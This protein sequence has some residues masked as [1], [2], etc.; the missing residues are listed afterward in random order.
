MLQ[1]PAEI[2]CH[3]CFFKD[4]FRTCGKIS[5]F[6]KIP[7]YWGVRTF[8][9]GRGYSLSDHLWHLFNIIVYIDSYTGL[10]YTEAPSYMYMPANVLHLVRAFLI[11]E[12]ALRVKGMEI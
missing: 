10:A 11:S 12:S 6:D 5:E 3:A 2:I 4:P 8:Q 7:G 9:A 1:E